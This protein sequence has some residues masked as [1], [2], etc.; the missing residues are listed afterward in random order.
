MLEYSPIMVVVPAVDLT[1]AK[2]FYQQTL[3]C[4][5]IRE[6]SDGIVLAC[7]RGTRLLIYPR[8]TPTQADHTTANWEV[9]NIEATIQELKSKGV[10]FEQYDQPGLKTNALG[11]A[12][13]NASKAA[14][15]KD[16]EGNILAITQPL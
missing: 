4:G 8:A 16:T 11:I 15:F 10:V 2:R 5:I 3:G 12:N 13:M 7:G 6:N 1:R 9:E 14:W